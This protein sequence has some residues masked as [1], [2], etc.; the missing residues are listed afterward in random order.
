MLPL[1]SQNL[2]RR[3]APPYSSNRLWVHIL[4]EEGLYVLWDWIG[5]A[6]QLPARGMPKKCF[7]LII[8]GSDRETCELW[9]IMKHL[10]M[11][12]EAMDMWAEYHE[13]TP[14][15][16][17]LDPDS[18]YHRWPL[19]WYVPSHFPQTV[20]DIM[21][22]TSI[23]RITGTDNAPWDARAFFEARKHWED[24]D[25]RTEFRE[26]VCHQGPRTTF[27]KDLRGRYRIDPDP[28]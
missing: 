10:A 5:E 18:D 15:H 21:H 3:A 23:V 1:R 25:W 4:G 2:D 26:R 6:L 19:P 11:L 13:K 24:W 7:K 16:V 20:R 27:F 17:T 8:D 14:P 9:D 28:Q 12:K 22:K